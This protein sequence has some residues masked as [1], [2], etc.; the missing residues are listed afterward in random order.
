[1]A[2]LLTILP[3]VWLGIWLSNQ[4]SYIA[5]ESIHPEFVDTMVSGMKPAF[6]L[7]NADTIEIANTELLRTI[8]LLLYGRF[9]IVLLFSY[10]GACIFAQIME[11]K[12]KINESNKAN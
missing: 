11:A 3:C 7:L 2:A 9:F 5:M 8:W 6:E 1:M 4:L 10:L 12:P